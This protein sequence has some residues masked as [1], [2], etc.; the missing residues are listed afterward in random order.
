LMESL[1]DTAEIMPEASKSNIHGDVPGQAFFWDPNPGVG[2]NAYK[3][4]LILHEVPR[5]ALHIIANR[6]ILRATFL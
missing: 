1:R 2:W 4:E 6:R 5:S 3:N